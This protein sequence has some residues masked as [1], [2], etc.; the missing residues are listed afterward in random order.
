M[1]DQTFNLADCLTPE[2]LRLVELSLHLVA[3]EYI[4]EEWEIHPLLGWD[5]KDVL[6]AHAKLCKSSK[7]SRKKLSI[8]ICCMNNIC[9]G[10]AYIAENA[11]DHSKI[12][13]EALDSLTKKLHR[14]LEKEPSP[15]QSHTADRI[16]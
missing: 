5:M 6:E 3:N 13:L 7:T 9:R 10:P 14:I 1:S 16:Q 12:D 8:A 2:E 11:L 4:I 15:D